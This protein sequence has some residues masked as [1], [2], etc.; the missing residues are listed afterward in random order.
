VELREALVNRLVLRGLGTV[1]VEDGNLIQR[2]LAN[3]NLEAKLA[4]ALLILKFLKINFVLPD[5]SAP[6][7]N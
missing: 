1:E 2:F 3:L 4:S 6:T 7:S 5:S